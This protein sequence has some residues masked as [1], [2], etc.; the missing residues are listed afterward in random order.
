M[1]RYEIERTKQILLY[2]CLMISDLFGYVLAMNGARETNKS[3][4]VDSAPPA[5][6]D[7]NKATLRVL[8]ILFIDNENDK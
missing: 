2:L 1:A 7:R 5:G 4:E 3:F 8:A 6:R